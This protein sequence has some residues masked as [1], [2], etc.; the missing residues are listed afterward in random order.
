[1]DPVPA[2]TT[3]P[4]LRDEGR[5][6]RFLLGL[7]PLL[8]TLVPAKAAI[9]AASTSDMTT[10]HLAMPSSLRQRAL[11]AAVFQTPRDPTARPSSFP[12]KR[13]RW[14]RKNAGRSGTVGEGFFNDHTRRLFPSRP[15]KRIQVP[16]LSTL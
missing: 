2:I 16:P 12:W 9:Q 7:V 1:M 11:R 5:G 3:M 10:T 6:T 4:E 13:L 8:S 15:T 14:R